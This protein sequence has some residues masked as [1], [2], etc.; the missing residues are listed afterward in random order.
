VPLRPGLPERQP[1]DDKRYGTTNSEKIVS[2]IDQ[3]TDPKLPR[4][5]AGKEMKPDPT[6]QDEK[7]VEPKRVR[8]TAK[9]VPAHVV[10]QRRGGNTPI[11]RRYEWAAKY[12]LKVPLKEIA[13][14]DADATTVGKVARRIVRSA[15]W[16]TR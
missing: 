14:A 11:D 5:L 12:L 6:G 1:H 9:K 8:G 3:M 7:I 10:G 16:A 15:G 13:G 2:R 4:E